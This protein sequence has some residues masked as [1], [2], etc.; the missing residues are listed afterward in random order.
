M[1]QDL[2]PD[3]DPTQCPDGNCPHP[4]TMIWPE[5]DAVAQAQYVNLRSIFDETLTEDE[6]EEHQ[7]KGIPFADVMA[8]MDTAP[9]ANAPSDAHDAKFMRDV[10]QQIERKIGTE[11]KMLQFLLLFQ[12]GR[13]EVDSEG[14]PYRVQIGDDQFETGDARFRIVFRPYRRISEMSFATGL[15]LGASV[16]PSMLYPDL[17]PPIAD[18]PTNVNVQGNT[19]FTDDFTIYVER[20]IIH[21]RTTHSIFS[22]TETEVT[23]SPAGPFQPGPTA[24][25]IL[26][27]IQR[28]TRRNQSVDFW[29]STGVLVA[30]VAITVAL[31]ATGA[32]A[33]AA[34]GRLARVAIVGAMVL[35]ASATTGSTLRYFGVQL[36]DGAYN[37]LI[38]LV[39]HIGGATGAS[40]DVTRRMEYTIHALNLCMAFGY[41]AKV[42]AISA[43]GTS[44]T[45]YG[46]MEYMNMSQGEME[47]Y[48]D[49]ENRGNQSLG[50]N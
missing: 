18:G 15:V 42:K 16:A 29:V 45:A 11:E 1:P 43:I 2:F 12:P 24:D 19:I 23:V 30:E 50:G 46:V 3:T 5:N 41:S 39:R 31:I 20:Q 47:A 34:A 36:N 13:G 40:S 9:P 14:Q 17:Q 49:T 28:Y 37:P 8:A 26:D 4:N 48:E 22:E 44:G 21:E 7:P 25:A 27:A 6:A 35:D 32:G 33:L 10:A 38:A